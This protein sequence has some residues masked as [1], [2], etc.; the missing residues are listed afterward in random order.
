MLACPK[1]SGLASDADDIP[2]RH[3]TG[4][5][6]ECTKSLTLGNVVVGVARP[7]MK[8]PRGYIDVGSEGV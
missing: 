7:S 5:T 4:A 2:S 3:G 8:C 1:Y 6:T